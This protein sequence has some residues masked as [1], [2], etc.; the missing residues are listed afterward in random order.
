MTIWSEG[1][2][3]VAAIKRR[4]FVL[5]AVATALFCFPGY[6]GTIGQWVNT[7]SN[8]LWAASGNFSS[9]YAAATSGTLSHTV[10]SGDQINS[11]VLNNRN[12]FIIANP[13]AVPSTFELNLLANWVRSGGILLLAADMYASDLAAL[14]TVL[15]ALGTPDSGQT[16]QYSSTLYG[17]GF[18][19]VTG[20][21][22]GTDAAVQGIT[23]R[24]LAMTNGY[25]LTGG[26]YLAEDRFWQNPN[27]GNFL[28]MD[29]YQLGKVYVF[30]SRLDINPNF[31]SNPFGYN[32]QFFHNLLGQNPFITGETPEPATLAITAFAL[33]G[34]G[35]WSRRRPPAR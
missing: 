21:L 30:G 15:Q 29:T 13:T 2:R 26:F 32:N 1:W 9:I 31:N 18:Q 4:F 14:N 6:G 20:S 5:I 25:T 11:N 3:S 24:P 7:P 34:L 23:G 33:I 16:I 35:L 8:S 10:T 19:T 17:A 28:R 27:L 22:Q 12:F